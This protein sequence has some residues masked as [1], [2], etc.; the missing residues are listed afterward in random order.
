MKKNL[1]PVTKTIVETAKGMRK[2]GLIDEEEYQK[3]TLRLLKKEKKLPKVE[4]ITSDEIRAIREREHIS[5]AVLANYLNLTVGYVSQLER[6]LKQPTGAVLA[7]L[8]IVRHKGL[9]SIQY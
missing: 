1:S 6:G 9:N 5:Q 4:P 7:L 3:I 2:I 8:N